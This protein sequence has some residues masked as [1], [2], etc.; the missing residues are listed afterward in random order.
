MDYKLVCPTEAQ[1]LLTM[2][3]PSGS[4]RAQN[5]LHLRWMFTC[6][7][8]RS[9]PGKNQA[10]LDRQK[11]MEPLE[12]WKDYAQ[13]LIVREDQIDQYKAHCGEHYIIVGLPKAMSIRLVKDEALIKVSLTRPA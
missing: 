11:A 12:L 3:Q 4:W 2:D 7:Y 9:E 5:D 13:V 6:S 8:K 10:F 1:R